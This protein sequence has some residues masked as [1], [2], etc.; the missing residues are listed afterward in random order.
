MNITN[1]DGG[2]TITLS[3]RNL[4]QLLAALDIE[5][6]P[7]GAVPSLHRMT[8]RGYLHITAEEND[9]HYDLRPEGPPGPGLEPFLG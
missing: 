7:S 5:D 8:Q 4:E 1:L 6:L 2:V 3:R 9:A